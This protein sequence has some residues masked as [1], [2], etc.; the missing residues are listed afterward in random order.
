MNTASRVCLLLVVLISIS[1]CQTNAPRESSADAAQIA[2]KIIAHLEKK[3]AVAPEQKPSTP[4]PPKPLGVDW[5]TKEAFVKSIEHSL[6]TFR[7]A[8]WN[9]YIDFQTGGRYWTH[10]GYGRWTVDKIGHIKL[11]N[12]F[13]PITHEL[14]LEEPYEPG[15]TFTGAVFNGT[16]NDGSKVKGALLR[17]NYQL[18]P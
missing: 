8:I 3:P 12:D 6:W 9:G 18:E 5:S 14:T 4:P 16:R 17:R 13:D 11:V 1:G 15:V 10:W 7:S 2:D